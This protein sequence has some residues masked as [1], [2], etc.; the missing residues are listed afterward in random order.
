MQLAGIKRRARN[1]S[2]KYRLQSPESVLID[3]VLLKQEDDTAS[4]IKNM[5]KTRS[6]KHCPFAIF[7]HRCYLGDVPAH[8]SQSY[9]F[10]M[11]VYDDNEG[12][13]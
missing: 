9:H 5:L 11:T 2:R 1:K 6:C 4:C 8:D 13:K 12:C 10:M 7:P 3:E